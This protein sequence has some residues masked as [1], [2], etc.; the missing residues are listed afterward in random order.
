[1][2]LRHPWAWVYKIPDTLHLGGKKPFDM[3]V[4]IDG[5]TFCLEFKR[6]DKTEPSE[7]QK[8][9]LDKVSRNGARTRIVN[10]VNFKEI[11]DEINDLVHGRRR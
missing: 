5:F 8:Y 10:E 6:G 1:M 7:F 9:N 11:L 4:I 2:K 3:I